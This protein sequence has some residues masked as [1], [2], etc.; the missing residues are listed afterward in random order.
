MKD[1]KYSSN[2]TVTPASKLAKKPK[3]KVK[4]TEEK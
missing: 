3:E 2:T 4:S 1:G